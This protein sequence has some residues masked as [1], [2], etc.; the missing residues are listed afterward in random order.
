MSSVYDWSLI[1]ANNANSD[2]D[3]NWAEGQP[4][5]SVNNSARVMMQRIKELLSDL[6]GV[7]VASGSPNVLAVTA[8]SSFSAYANGLRVTFRAQANNTGSA[9]LNV[10][11]VGAKPLVKISSA[12][13]SQVAAGEIKATGIY[14]AIYS[15][16]LN[17]ASGAWLLLNPTEQT[18]PA[19]AIDLFGMTALPIGW[20]ECDG[21]AVSRSTYATL[22]AAIG[23]AWGSGDGSTTFNIPDLRGEFLRGWDHGRGVDSGRAFAS[24]QDSQNKE[25]QHTGTTGAGSPH[26]HGTGFGNYVV[27]GGSGGSVPGAGASFTVNTTFEDDHTH[28][29]TTGNSGGNEARP[30]NRAIIFGIKT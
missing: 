27:G 19:G 4:P 16:V 11:A 3:I 10:N 23:T 29:F 18:I 24:F 17:G 28:P 14:E 7:A 25:H 21:S 2:A 6:G 8:A 5:G 20:L 15:T 30:R 1:A 13:E 9:T 26:Q 12:G 22:F